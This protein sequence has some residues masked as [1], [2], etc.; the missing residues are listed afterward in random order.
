MEPRRPCNKLDTNQIPRPWPAVL[1]MITVHG[2][3]PRPV[4]STTE[5]RAATSS[6]VCCVAGAFRSKLPYS[7]DAAWPALACAASLVVAATTPH[8]CCRG[9]DRRFPRSQFPRDQRNT[10][11]WFSLFLP[12]RLSTVSRARSVFERHKPAQ[13]MN[14]D[15]GL[16]FVHVSSTS[17]FAVLFAS[18]CPPKRAL[19]SIK[20]RALACAITF[21]SN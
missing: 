18:L 16:P 12:L 8:G 1:Q 14:P 2:R 4:P 9:C 3:L 5:S 7:I 20:S 17:R 11:S 15:D 6:S 21:A 19:L 10:N 13:S